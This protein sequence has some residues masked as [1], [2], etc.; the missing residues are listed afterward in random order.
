M[1]DKLIERIEKLNNPTAVGLDTNF[2]YLP[3]NMKKGCKTLADASKAINEFNF[4]LIDRLKSLVP[5]VKV[6]VAYYEMYGVDGMRAFSDT[7]TYAKKN[8]LVTIADCKRNDI[9]STAACY[10]S[11]Y[12]GRVKV[13]EREF[14]PF[15]SD[16]L[17]VNGYLGTDGLDPFIVD[18]R[19][20]DKG[21]FVLVKTS[22]PSSGQL[23][24]VKSEN[25][26]TLYENMGALVAEC[27]KSSVG[28]YGYSDVGAVIGA[29]HPTQAEAV[30]KE[31]ENLFF[32]IPGYGAQGGSADGL[33]VC[34]DS[35]GRGGIVNNSRGIICAYKKDKFSGM[36][37]AQAAENAVIEMRE[38][39]YGALKRA[40]KAR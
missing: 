9:G 35:H 21:I 4:T 10:S 12:L 23:Q 31:F 38:D 18:C 36:N 2:D 40:G 17:T 1:I 29:T 27:G 14:A 7:L 32:L 8:G 39:I 13:G 26:K 15:E 25:G 28:K 37:F 16:F 34:F 5:A 20:Y 24:D 19:K 6:Q 11:A 3:D 22:N 30:R 33:T